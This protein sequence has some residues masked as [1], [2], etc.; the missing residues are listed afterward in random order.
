MPAYEFECLKCGEQVMLII[1]ISDYEKKNYKCPE[2]GSKKLE[3]LVSSVQV[4]TS[5]KS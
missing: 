3:R 4:V 5:K 1:P 2:C